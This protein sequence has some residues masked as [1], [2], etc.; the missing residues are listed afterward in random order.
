MTKHSFLLIDI[1][2]PVLFLYTPTN[3]LEKVLPPFSVTARCVGYVYW[4][5]IFMG[6]SWTIFR[7]YSTP[8]YYLGKIC[9][10]WVLVSSKWLKTS[11]ECDSFHDEGNLIS[12]IPVYALNSNWFI[13]RKYLP[14]YYFPPLPECL[15]VE[16]T[17]KWIKV[18]N[19]FSNIQSLFWCL[20]TDLKYITSHWYSLIQVKNII[21]RRKL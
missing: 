8:K 16:N 10:Q 4:W 15:K 7:F 2:F 1:T 13:Y 11:E 19:T 5:N 12:T 6:L 17:H 3:S 20:F 21:M 9:L 14:W 18:I